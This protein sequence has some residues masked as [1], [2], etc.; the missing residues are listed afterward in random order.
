V[1]RGDVLALVGNSGNSLAPHLHF[2]VM[3][4]PLSLASNGLPYII[5]LYTVTGQS[6]GTDAFDKAEQEGTRLAVTPVDAAEKIT[7]A[8]PLDQ[9]VMDFD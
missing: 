9:R 8:M 4:G 3:S 1:E 7:N 5:D 2:H 6:A